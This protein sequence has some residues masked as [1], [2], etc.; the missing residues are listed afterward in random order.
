MIGPTMPA[1]LETHVQPFP[2][3]SWPSA[4][5]LKA[6]SSP[7]AHV[8]FPA[9]AKARTVELLRDLAPELALMGVT[10][11]ALFGS[12]AAATTAKTATSPCPR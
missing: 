9:P 5:E 3:M 1:Q 7:N 4:A 11:I 6:V 2:P 8:D 12:V 10:K